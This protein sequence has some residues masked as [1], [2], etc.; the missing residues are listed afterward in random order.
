METPIEMA[1][2]R[3]SDRVPEE[4]EDRAQEELHRAQEE[5]VHRGQDAKAFRALSLGVAI[6]GMA[7]WV[8]VALCSLTAPDTL[9]LPLTHLT[10]WL[11]EDTAGVI[12]FVLSFAGFIAYRLSRSD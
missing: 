10:P 12:A 9:Q 1:S 5:E 3:D 11:R 4:P 2:R 8:Y 7:G 6:Y